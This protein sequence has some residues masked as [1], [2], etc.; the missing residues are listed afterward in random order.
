MTSGY[1]RT[2]ALSYFESPKYAE[3]LKSQNK[4]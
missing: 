2:Q 1:F 3:K 4:S